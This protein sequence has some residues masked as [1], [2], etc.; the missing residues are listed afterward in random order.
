MLA[1]KEKTNMA[2]AACREKTKFKPVP[3]N[4]LVRTCRK[5][6]CMYAH[7]PQMPTI[8]PVVIKIRTFIVRKLSP[9]PPPGPYSLDVQKSVFPREL[10]PGGA[11]RIPYGPHT[12][13]RTVM[14][15]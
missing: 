12:V 10:G 1:Y 4:F 7:N 11:D 14:P 13:P 8:L 2:H 6:R 3:Y 15:I 9:P 5:T